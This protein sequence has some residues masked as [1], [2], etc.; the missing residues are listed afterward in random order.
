MPPESS[1]VWDLAWSPDG[2]RL[3]IG[4]SDGGVVVWNVRQVRA[5]LANFDISVPSMDTETAAPLKSDTGRIPVPIEQMTLVMRFRDRVYSTGWSTQQALSAADAAAARPFLLEALDDWEH[6][7]WND[8][9][10]WEYHLGRARIHSLLSVASILKRDFEAARR[11][12]D[13]GKNVCKKLVEYFPKNPVCRDGLAY[14]YLSEASAL[15]ATGQARQAVVALRQCVALREQLAKE[16]PQ[17]SQYHAQLSFAEYRLS[18]ALKSSGR[19]EEAE[20]VNRQAF[21]LLVQLKSAYPNALEYGTG[22]ATVCKDYGI[23]LAATNREEEAVSALRQAIAL[24]AAQA[25]AHDRLAQLLA[26]SSN[27]EVRN[28]AKAVEAGKRA[29]ELAPTIG[30]F[31]NTLGTAYYQAGDWHAAVEAIEKARELSEARESPDLFVLAMA[32]WRLGDK[33][34]A[35]REYEEAVQELGKNQTVDAAVIRSRDEAAVL[36]GIRDSRTEE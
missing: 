20:K 5:E 10:V 15:E 24:D 30:T 6:R 35:R 33:S 34:K 17:L 31:W 28:P 14:L 16:G 22:A 12:V 8:A 2:S 18:L 36:L 25:A 29:V 19:F 11:H 21:D 3:A 32:H 26:T 13:Q 23:L 1:E 27:P 4:L 9:Q 7:A